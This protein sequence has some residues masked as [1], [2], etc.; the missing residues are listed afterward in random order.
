M[1]HPN[2]N[3]PVHQMEAALRALSED[4]EALNRLAALSVLTAEIEH[5]WV[6]EMAWRLYA[7]GA[8]VLRE[9]GVDIVG[10]DTCGLKGVCGVP[11]M[12]KKKEAGKDLVGVLANVKI[13]LVVGNCAF[14]VKRTHWY[15]AR[16]HADNMP[17]TDNWLGADIR[18]LRCLLRCMP[19]RFARAYLII[20]MI[21]LI[22]ARHIGNR[23][24]AQCPDESP[25][26]RR[27]D[28]DTAI[29]YY[30]DSF[31]AYANATE[32]HLI[33]VGTG[34]V[35]NDGGNVQFDAMILRAY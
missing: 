32:K 4:H 20:A 5:D 11:S 30:L 12:C 31:G 27:A 35:P 19:G 17:A 3:L 13:D 24:I 23:E 1:A 15:N 16:K 22:D 33:E 8:E 18:K 26:Q 25:D 14:E 34:T 21:T 29:R 9:V 7:D 6:S 2:D 28:R 10:R